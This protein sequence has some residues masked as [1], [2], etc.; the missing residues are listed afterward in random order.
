MLG[1]TLYQ[2]CI[3]ASTGELEGDID[4]CEMCKKLIINAGIETVVYRNTSTEY[5]VVAVDEWVH[6]E[7]I[8]IGG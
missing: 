6:N 7:S 8:P 3:T 2:S 1:A 5:R 4:S